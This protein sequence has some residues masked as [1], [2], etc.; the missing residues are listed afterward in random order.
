MSACEGVVRTLKK[1]S[2]M[3]ASQFVAAI[4]QAV[5]R[6]SIQGTLEITK[7]PPGRRRITDFE[8]GRA[9]WLESLGIEESEYIESILA[10]AVDNALFGVLCVVDGVRAVESTPIKGSFELWY[11]RGDRKLL[12]RPEDPYLHDLYDSG[13][14]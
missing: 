8:R 1:G 13:G 6:S 3:D 10:D 9:R 11:V 12:N 5:R 14:A 7:N 4:K 2:E